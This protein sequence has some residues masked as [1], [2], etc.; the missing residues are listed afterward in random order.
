MALTDRLR[1]FISYA[2][3]DAASLA[4]R[5]HDDLSRTY[6]VWLDRKDLSGGSTWT[7]EIE[8]ALDQSNLLLAVLSSGAYVSEICRAEQL[9]AL[10]RG[11]RVIPLLAEHAADIPLHLETKH[12]LDFSQVSLYAQRLD[13]LL[14]QIRGDAS[15][16]LNPNY[17]STYVTAPPLPENYV[18]RAEAV[19]ALRDA[20]F[21][22]GGRRQIALTAFAGMGGIGKSVL[23]QALCQD[24]V[25]Q[26]AFPDG[27]IWIAAGKES[28]YDLVSRMREVGK[29]LN[30]DLT[31]YDSEAGAVNQYRSTIRH[32]AALIVVDDVWCVRDL[33]P[34]RGES[35]RSRLLFTTRNTDLAAAVGARM[36][37]A[38]LLNEE[39]SREVLKRYSQVDQLPP[40]AGDLIAECGHLPLALSMIGAMLFR[41]PLALWKR[42]LALLRAADLANIRVQLPDYPYSDVFRAIQVSV[43]ALDPHLRERYL[44]VSVLLEDMP[45]QS[46]VQQAL[47]CVSESEA[48]ETAEQFV[49]L[50]LARRDGNSGAIKLH[51]LQLDYVRALYLDRK[52]LSLIHDAV[53]LSFHIIVNDASQFASQLVGRLLPWKG[54]EVIG[55]FVST[56]TR[57]SP[58][59][60]IRPLHP[61]LLPPGTGL[62]RTLKGH[63]APVDS[64]ALS[65]EDRRVVST[66]SGGPTIN[67]WDLETGQLLLKFEGHSA[68]ICASS[69]TTGNRVVSVSDDGTLHI[70]ELETGH[71]IRTLTIDSAELR[72]VCVIRD[73]RHALFGAIDGT[74]RI[75]DLEAARELRRL[76]GHSDGINAFAISPDERRVISASADKTLK[77]W[78]LNTGEELWTLRGHTDSVNA[79]ALYRDGNKAIS[80][81]NDYSL[82]VWDLET[83]R[84]LRTLKGHSHWVLGAAVTPDGSRAVSASSDET[85]K[86]WDLETGDVLLT[87]TGHYN[88]VKCVAITSDGRRAV[89]GSWDSTL[90][91][92]DLGRDV[93]IPFRASE[94]TAVF[95][96]FANADGRRILSVSTDNV[97]RIWDVESGSETGTVQEQGGTLSAVA[98]T[99]D[100]SSALIAGDYV[101]RLWDLK[102]GNKIGLLDDDTDWISALA[103]T[104][105]GLYAVIPS[106]GTLKA[107]D[108]TNRRLLH[109]LE[110]HPGCVIN[111]VAMSQDGR[112]AVSAAAD[113]NLKVWCLKSGSQIGIVA[114]HSE[115]INDVVLSP[116]GRRAV[117]CSDDRTMKLWDL[118]NMRLLRTLEGHTDRVNRMSMS[119][120]G[121]RVL[122]V[123]ADCSLKLWDLETG[124][125]L[126]TFTGDSPLT[127]CQ[128]TGPTTVVAGDSGGRV[129][130]LCLEL[131][132]RAS[133]A[134]G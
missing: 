59:P 66:S 100:W 67:V 86:L 75:W 96:V 20:L 27:I 94:D 125:N 48:L 93:V 13:D 46:V 109:T 35:V 19:A 112:V 122:S 129:H 14:Q 99:P 36:H 29:A 82:K 101:L 113:C 5:L 18:E 88:M 84:E 126:V 123:S 131:V 117:S 107:W 7:A 9:R 90:K 6:E 40:Q 81:S 30:D 103:I 1:I 45:V 119:A 16:P 124:L 134:D 114:A 106:R 108:L 64:V 23:A 60:W 22:S 87:M 63:A 79:V 132:N 92:W 56:I 41:K 121:R 28:A 26:Q 69:I 127:C 8:K 105:D 12:Y 68:W 24:E 51:D 58:R 3:Q 38:D 57:C 33:K 70:W 2:H 78:D 72:G 62:I 74:L 53:R 52:A 85:L 130:M 120:D 89:S 91:L 47:W 31:R 21:A 97:L 37:T 104:S 61:S 76:R 49:S 54:E 17:R 133:K 98:L 111:A 102:S 118:N 50:S 116:D 25:V 34:F 11:K 32:K 128:F 43:D 44:A 10:R 83:G 55:R 110:G 115:S 39:Q 95:R 80:G 73:G 65:A 4:Q 77:V 42:T 15:V 71:I